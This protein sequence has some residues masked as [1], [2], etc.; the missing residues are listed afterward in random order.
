MAAD[1]GAA[2]KRRRYGPE[3]WALNFET[4]GRLGADGIALLKHLA[5][6]ASCWSV[7]VQKRLARM[8]R[9]KLERALIHAQAEG[10]LLCMGANLECINREA[11]M[12]QARR[13]A[14]SSSLSARAGAGPDAQAS[15]SAVPAYAGVARAGAGAHHEASNAEAARAVAEAHRLQS[16][17]VLADTPGML[18][19]LGGEAAQL[20]V[21]PATS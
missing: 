18:D 8:W 5:S 16:P 21:Q 10:L 1:A 6:E 9:A 3:V 13:I 7:G 14:E 20:H 17:G 19:S 12:G 2:D 4:R 11:K 15:A